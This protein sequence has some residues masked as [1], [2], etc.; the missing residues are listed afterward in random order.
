MKKLLWLCALLVLAS[1]AGAGTSQAPA[2]APFF[3]LQFS[4]PQFGMFTADKDFAQET[5][6]FEFAIASANRL[7]PAFVVVT[8]DLVNKAGDAAQ[9]AEYQRIAATLDRS[10]PLYNVAGNHDVENTPTAETIAAY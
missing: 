7:K 1:G 2:D 4:D 10:I 9:I 3:F 8:G 6:N 5:A